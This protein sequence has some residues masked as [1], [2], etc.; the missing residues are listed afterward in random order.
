[1]PLHA[2]GNARERI[3]LMGPYGAGKSF[4]W[5]QI[6]EWLDRTQ[7]DAKVFVLDSLATAERD[8]GHLTNVY[9]YDWSSWAELEQHTDDAIRFATRGVDWL[10]VDLITTVWDV[11]QSHYIERV[12]ARP[13][14]RAS[15]W[16]LDWR[17]EGGQGHPL[18]GA[19]AYG[20]NWSHIKAYYYDWINRIIRY[21]GHLLVCA[22]AEGVVKADP[23]NPNSRSDPI[24]ILHEFGPYGYKPKGEKTLAQPFHTILMLNHPKPNEWSFTTIRDR[25]RERIVNEPLQDFVVQYLVKVA[26][27]EIT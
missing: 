14:E 19:E 6:A 27:W 2:P 23:K 18:V 17:A 9:V 21:P 15:T 3:L 26:G 5:T 11:A 12:M 10:I 25:R 20:M 22:S 4:A 16:R 1:M 24:E 7:S 8:A 13:G